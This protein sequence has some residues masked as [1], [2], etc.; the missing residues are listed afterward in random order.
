MKL[1]EYLQNLIKNKKEQ[2]QKLNDSLIECES[3]EQRSSILN[4]INTLDSEIRDGEAQ[5]A[6]IE[7]EEAAKAAADSNEARNAFNPN[8]ALNVVQ[9]TVTQNAGEARSEEN[10]LATMEYRKAFMNYVQRGVKSEILKFEKRDGDAVGVAS[11]LGVL[12]PETIVQEIITGV[13]KVYGQLYS[14]V[15][16]TNIKG[17][18]KYPI[19]SFSATFKRIKETGVGSAPS[20]RQKAGSAPGYV[21]F[22]YLIGEIRIART[23]LQSVLSV[24]AFEKEVAK[25]IIEAYVKAMDTEIMVGDPD[26]GEMTGILTE[27][28]K[29]N[30][31]RFKDYTDHVIEFTPEDMA[32]WTK[33]Q[34][35]LFAVIPLS[36]R[37]MK[38]QFAMTAN[39]YE[40]NIKTL[41][42]DNNRP[43]YNETFNP[44]DGAERSTFK[45]KEV[46]FVEEDILANFN[47]ADEGDFFGMYWVP[48]EA[49]AINSNLQFTMVKYFDQEKNEYVDKALVINDGKVLDAKYIYLLKKKDSEITG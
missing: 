44:V 40:A 17:G 34:E 8:A 36:M 35:K 48:E 26:D 39:T 5:I 15:R 33:W 41:H 2:R 6:N 12:L 20:D 29:G 46:A 1:K 42:D 14:R 47:D 49:Y 38:P 19:G 30:Q 16:K 31:G 18:V 22:S 10:P 3:K 27:L 11:D 25:V 4:T 21:E 23:L 9:K 28:A 37:G 43:V 7:A 13:E 32:D 24:P 45:G